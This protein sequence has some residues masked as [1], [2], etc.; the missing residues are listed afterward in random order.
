MCKHQALQCTQ[1][2][3]HCQL[4]TQEQLVQAVPEVSMNQ[5]C[6]D[7][8]TTFVS[9][10]S[11]KDLESHPNASAMQG[12]RVIHDH[13]SDAVIDAVDGF[14]IR[15]SSAV[16][17]RNVFEVPDDLQSS[18]RDGIESE[19]SRVQALA[20]MALG[21]ACGF[22]PA[23]CSNEN[24]GLIDR[25]VLSVLGKEDSRG[26][27]GYGGLH[28]H[29]EHSQNGF[30]GRGSGVSPSVDALII[31][32]LR[33]PENDPTTI[34]PLTDVLSYLPDH[35][36]EWAQL[37]IFSFN[38][39]DS[40][41]STDVVEGVSLL[42]KRYGRFEVVWNAAQL[43]ESED[44]RAQAVATWIRTALVDPSIRRKA[45]L[46]PGDVLVVDNRTV[47]H[48]RDTPKSDKRWFKRVFGVRP[49]SPNVAADPLKPWKLSMDEEK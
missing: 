11:I 40:T 18:P 28:D 34:V 48:G 21:Q 49:E 31:A 35:I 16:V 41:T 42:R 5:E 20:A 43:R 6:R 32:M 23:S 10:A 9:T 46:N 47:V 7:R 45:S 29:T 15:A 3:V 36:I 17:F 44:S 4:E 38:P 22:S 1:D 25:S 27:H 8:L 33:N 2:C 14:A 24:S 13:A 12:A 37:P 26:S 39:S 30:Q 19:A